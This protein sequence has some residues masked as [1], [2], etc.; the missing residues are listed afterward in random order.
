MIKE[1]ERVSPILRFGLR[2]VEVRLSGIRW[3]VPPRMESITCEILVD[4]DETDDRL[5]LLH[6]NVR[7]YGTVFNTVSPGTHLEG[8]LRR[9]VRDA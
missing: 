6:D 8:T 3:D 2:S 1:I 7:K 4:T 9:L 5:R